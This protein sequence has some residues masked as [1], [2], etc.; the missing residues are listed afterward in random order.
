M[1]LWGPDIQIYPGIHGV[2]TLMKEHHFSQWLCQIFLN[3]LDPLDN[4][5][6]QS[7]DRMFSY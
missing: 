6:L 1:L 5:E 3:K 2:S 4:T 7:I